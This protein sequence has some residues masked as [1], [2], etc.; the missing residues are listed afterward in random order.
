[1]RIEALQPGE[2][3]GPTPGIPGRVA[4]HAA[5][6]PGG[7][8]KPAGKELPP[9]PPPVV[10]DV[11]AAAELIDRFLRSAGRELSFSVDQVTGRTVV[12]IRDPATG[13]LIRQLPSEEALRIARHLD[14]AGP[15]LA[16]E[17]A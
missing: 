8:S 5:P 1:M 17:L 3:K 9:A 6:P 2:I 13:T 10:R 14:L 15:V 11:H 4:V 7:E 12:A 16:S